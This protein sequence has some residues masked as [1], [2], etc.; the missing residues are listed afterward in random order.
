VNYV[1]EILE[2]VGI[3][4]KRVQMF[5]CSAAEGKRF[6]EE[7]TRISDEIKEIG[8]SPFKQTAQNKNEKS[9]ESKS[10]NK[11]NAK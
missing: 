1:R 6:Q 4:P 2:S 11:K 5:Y 9:K 7:V 10:K 8:K 3:S